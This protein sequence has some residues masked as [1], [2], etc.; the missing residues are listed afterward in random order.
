MK[1]SEAVTVAGGTPSIELTIGTSTVQATLA[2]GSGTD[3]LVFSYVIGAGIEGA[4]S[5]ASEISL[6]SATMKDSAGDDA[7]LELGSI[8]TDGVEVIIE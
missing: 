6:N 8:N 2:S 5:A 3:T 7:S 4:V 1:F